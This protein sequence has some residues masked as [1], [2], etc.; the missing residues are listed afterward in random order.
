LNTPISVALVFWPPISATIASLP[1]FIKLGPKYTLPEKPEDRQQIILLMLSNLLLSCW[2]G[3][4][5]STQDWLEQYPSLL[6]GDLSRSAFV[7]DLNPRDKPAPRGAILL[8]RAGET[9]EGQLAGRPWSEV[10]R[11]LFELNQRKQEFVDDVFRLM[12]DLEENQLWQLEARPVP[13]REYALQLFAIWTGPTTDGAGYYMTK[14][15]LINRTP[16]TRVAP[17]ESTTPPAVS[18]IAQVACGGVRGP[19][20][21]KPDFS[22]IEITPDALPLPETPSEAVSGTEAM[23]QPETAPVP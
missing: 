21:G 8:E 6:S 18:G 16:G 17:G 11:W 15:C 22:R 4:Y 3:L 20:A 1:K 7:L 13:G 19:F 12:T 10:E 5:F 9:V 23:P 2:I 14:T